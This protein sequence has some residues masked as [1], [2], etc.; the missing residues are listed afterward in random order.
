MASA[1]DCAASLAYVYFEHD[2]GRRSPAKLLIK[3]EARRI[4][5]FCEQTS[6][7]SL[8]SGGGQPA[9]L[10]SPSRN[11]LRDAS[12][13]SGKCSMDRVSTVFAEM[14]DWPRLFAS[15]LCCWA[16]LQWQGR[17]FR[18]HGHDRLT[19]PAIEL[20]P[21]RILNHRYVSSNWAD[22]PSLRS[23]RRLPAPVNA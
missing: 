10:M 13:L 16:K 23:C 9:P 18:C 22:L 3:D 21:P 14:P 2:P 12:V 4:A 7:T 19:F 1:T 11:P 8:R 15:S 5:V 17:R 6:R 20:R